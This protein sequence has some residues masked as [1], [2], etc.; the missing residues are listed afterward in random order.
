MP[1]RETRSMDLLNSPDNGGDLQSLYR[2]LAQSGI[3]VGDT[4]INPSELADELFRQL[5]A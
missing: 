2:E 1:D 5:A 4:D 3:A